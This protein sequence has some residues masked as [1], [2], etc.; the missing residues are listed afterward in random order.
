[1]RY[2]HAWPLLARVMDGIYAVAGDITN[3]IN[4][5]IDA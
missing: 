3:A 2:M 5:L 4:S 1:M